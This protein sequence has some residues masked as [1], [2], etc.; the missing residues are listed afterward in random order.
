MKR[1]LLLGS[2]LF[3][4]ASFIKL[5]SI[6]NDPRPLT[7]Y[8]SE[9]ESCGGIYNSLLGKAYTKVCK[10]GYYC[11]VQTYGFPSQSICIN[12]DKANKWPLKEYPLHFKG[13]D[14]SRLSPSNFIPLGDGGLD[15][16]FITEKDGCLTSQAW[17][18]NKWELCTELS[19]QY[20]IDDCYKLLA[21][22][23]NN[24]KI[25]EAN[26]VNTKLCKEYVINYWKDSYAIKGSIDE[27][28]E[29]NPLW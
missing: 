23:L 25:C 26:N 18:E 28:P 5:I 14:C 29:Y 2:I 16:T 3:I 24:T 19:S 9:S 8:S 10:D 7:F 27:D 1:I 13:I 20:K 15:P 21:A 12:N 11:Q 4:I 22:K 6:Y 17:F